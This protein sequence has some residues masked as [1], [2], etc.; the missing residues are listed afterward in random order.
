MLS[1][2]HLITNLL[3]IGVLGILCCIC[4]VLTEIRNQLRD[5]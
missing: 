4:A 3:L 2:Q 1:L 5:R